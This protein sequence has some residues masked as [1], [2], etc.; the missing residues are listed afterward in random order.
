MG[1]QV[2]NWALEL[3]QQKVK[4]NGLAP[5]DDRVRSE[6]FASPLDLFAGMAGADRDPQICKHFFDRQC[7][8]TERQQL[9]GLCFFDVLQNWPPPAK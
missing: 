1:P 6:P 5:G 4:P 2:D 9:A 8:S 3:M 7:V